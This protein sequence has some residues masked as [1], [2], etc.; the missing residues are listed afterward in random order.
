MKIAIIGYSGAGKSTLA[1]ELSEL[2]NITPLYLDSINF[3]PNWVKKEP[4]EVQE[5][6][7]SF[8]E[9]HENFVVD[10]N[11]SKVFQN[12]FQ[13]VDRIIFLNFNRF[14]CLKSVIKRYQENKGIVRYSCAPGCKDKID[15]EFIKWVLYKGR[16][17][18]QKEYYKDIINK[19]K[20][21]VLVFKNRKEVNKFLEKEKKACD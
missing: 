11:W 16:S 20:D 9:E 4:S 21:K 8:L 15:L 19:Y 14:F 17:K 5:T 6:I 1:K 7:D 13:I 2:Y 18:K 10:G 12:R 3:H